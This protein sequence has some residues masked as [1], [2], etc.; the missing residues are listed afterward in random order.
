[1][2]KSYLKALAFVGLL[3]QLHS[4][5][6]DDVT[7]TNG[8]IVLHGRDRAAIYYLRKDQVES[9]T[10][11]W[12]KYCG[13]NTVCISVP[14][15]VTTKSGKELAVSDDAASILKQIKAGVV[16]SYDPS[17][18]SGH[19]SGFYITSP[20]ITYTCIGPPGAGAYNSLLPGVKAGRDYNTLLPGCIG[21]V[22]GY[23]ENP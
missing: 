3:A 1:M 11:Q 7:V 17:L 4:A 21:C 18:Y 9:V 20:P 15:T 5:K 22:L 12:E 13:A 14:T 16:P 2:N 10:T 23:K 6:A 19:C 8:W